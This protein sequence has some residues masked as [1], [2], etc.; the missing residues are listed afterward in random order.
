LLIGG[1]YVEAFLFAAAAAALG[2]GVWLKFALVTRAAFHEPF[3]LP[4]APV[5]GTR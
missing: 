3:T 4:R 1:L 2:T 5:R